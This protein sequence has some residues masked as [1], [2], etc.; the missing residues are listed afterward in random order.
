[1][2]A[3]FPWLLL[4]RFLAGFTAACFFTLLSM[5]FSVPLRGG[6]WPKFGAVSGLYRCH[7]I[8][9]FR[10]GRAG[11]LAVAPARLEDHQGKFDE[12]MK[13]FYSPDIVSTA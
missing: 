13:T 3:D 2:L 8:L 11:Q 12:A 10:S 4:G 7:H 1:M 6:S 9:V 5:A